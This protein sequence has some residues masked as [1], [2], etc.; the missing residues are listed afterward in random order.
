MRKKSLVCVFK[1]HCRSRNEHAPPIITKRRFFRS[2][3]GLPP[4]RRRGPTSDAACGGRFFSL[5][6]LGARH[7]LG[8]FFL[9]GFARP[10]G[11]RVSCKAPARAQESPASKLKWRRPKQEG[12]GGWQGE[13]NSGV[14]GA[15]CRGDFGRGCGFGPTSS[16]WP[17]RWRGRFSFFYVA[18]GPTFA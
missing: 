15:L 17:S 16:G 14:T 8:R 9:S 4:S 5:F 1:H 2:P 7:R 3:Q 11:G 10:D 18:Q 6:R 12:E 13:S